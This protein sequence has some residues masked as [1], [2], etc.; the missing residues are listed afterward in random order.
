MKYQ[1]MPYEKV[2]FDRVEEEFK[3]LMQE[4]QAAKSG[5]EQFAVH[6]KYYALRDRVDTMMTLAHTR[7]DCNTADAF[8]S[9][10]QDYY[11]EWHFA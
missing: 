10:Q 4:F 1:D 9:E 11:D 7:H 2:D 3:A 8:Y 5:E 6:Q